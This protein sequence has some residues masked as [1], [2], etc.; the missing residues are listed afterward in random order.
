[1][2]S[3]TIHSYICRSDSEDALSAL[4]MHAVTLLLSDLECSQAC[5]QSTHGLDLTLELEISEVLPSL[6]SYFQS[7]SWEQLNTTLRNLRGHRNI[8]LRHFAVVLICGGGKN[9]QKDAIIDKALNTLR[10]GLEELS[11]VK[12]FLQIRLLS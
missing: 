5:T 12:G 4:L 6:P 11:L 1:M 3:L 8:R 7:A 9:V 2:E 10:K